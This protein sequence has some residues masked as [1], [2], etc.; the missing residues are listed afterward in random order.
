MQAAMQS[1]NEGTYITQWNTN[2]ARIVYANLL[3]NEEELQK[4]VKRE[5]YFERMQRA[6]INAVQ[7]SHEQTE[8]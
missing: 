1:T 6:R 8:L 7:T 5:R 2:V 3:T 4:R